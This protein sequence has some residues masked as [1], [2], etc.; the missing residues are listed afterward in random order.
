MAV[1]SWQI[2]WSTFCASENGDDDKCKIKCSQLILFV[3]FSALSAFYF[4]RRQHLL[5]RN[6]TQV[7]C[8]HVRICTMCCLAIAASAKLYVELIAPDSSISPVDLL[9]CCYQTIAA[10]VHCGNAPQSCNL[11]RD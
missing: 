4:G 2:F 8:I 9:G 5:V 3:M 6:K 10:I 11:L 7:I 1:P